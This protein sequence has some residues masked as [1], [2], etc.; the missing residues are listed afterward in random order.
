MYYV[1]MEFYFIMGKCKPVGVIFAENLLWCNRKYNLKIEITDSC[2]IQ[3]LF[4]AVSLYLSKI[5][6]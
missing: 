4:N 3:Y 5:I 6:V 1:K 2:I